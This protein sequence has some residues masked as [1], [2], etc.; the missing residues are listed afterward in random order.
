MASFPV[1]SAQVHPGPKPSCPP[2]KARAFSLLPKEVSGQEGF[3]FRTR[4]SAQ[5]PHRR[6]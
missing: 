3:I 4:T 6:R 2:F 1:N 5:M